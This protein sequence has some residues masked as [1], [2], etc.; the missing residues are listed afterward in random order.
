MKLAAQI[1]A[2]SLSTVSARGAEPPVRIHLIEDL[3]HGLGPE[4]AGGVRR[5][6]IDYGAF[7]IKLTELKG[8]A[9]TRGRLANRE[10]FY[11]TIEGKGYA[12]GLSRIQR[13][14]MSS[15]Q[16][17]QT[18]PFT[19][20]RLRFIPKSCWLPSVGNPGPDL[21]RVASV[22]G[23]RDLKR[24][25]VRN[26]KLRTQ[27][28]FLHALLIQNYIPREVPYRWAQVFRGQELGVGFLQVN[29]RRLNRFH[30]K[31][32]TV[33]FVVRGEPMFLLK[34]RSLRAPLNSIVV[35]SSNVRHAIRGPASLIEVTI[36]PSDEKEPSSGLAQ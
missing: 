2:L 22:L 13:R 5:T 21:L 19:A 26:P 1:L 35:I 32:H 27:N 15:G 33:Y 11:R 16:P 31:G 29:S 4:D 18:W 14:Q 23:P 17:V 8:G 20:G 10:V 9:E 34:P 25:I 24:P 7:E 6:E 36:P 3:V 12:Q 28:Q 30:S